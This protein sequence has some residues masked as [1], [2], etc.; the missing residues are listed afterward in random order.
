MKIFQTVDEY[1]FV[2][3]CLKVKPNKILICNKKTVFSKIEYESQIYRLYLYNL[4]LIHP[5]YTEIIKILKKLLASYRGGMIA[6]QKIELKSFENKYN[7]YFKMESNKQQSIDNLVSLIDTTNI[8]LIYLLYQQ[9]KPD[10]QDENISQLFRTAILFRDPQFDYPTTKKLYETIILAN[11]LPDLLNVINPESK[12]FIELITYIYNNT[13]PKLFEESFHIYF[14]IFYFPN[15]YDIDFDLKDDELYENLIEQYDT[16]YESDQECGIDIN[17]E[18]DDLDELARMKHL[19]NIEKNYREE[20]L[21]EHPEYDEA[22]DGYVY[23]LYSPEMVKEEIINIRKLLKKLIQTETNENRKLALIINNLEYVEMSPEES[24]PYKKQWDSKILPIIKQCGELA[25]INYK[26]H[27]IL[28]KEYIDFFNM[29][30]KELKQFYEY[31]ESTKKDIIKSFNKEKDPDVKLTLIIKYHKFLD[32]KEE[33]L[34]PYR[35]RWTEEVEPI[36]KK[37]EKEKDEIKK[38]SLIIDNF[39]FLDLFEDDKEDYIEKYNQLKNIKKYSIK[40]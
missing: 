28:K 11:N 38:L 35:K 32:M 26:Q 23:R 14:D 37:I 18:S 25:E 9:L 15:D 8:N 40:K 7:Q 2:Y 3:G 39:K 30:K 1:C 17:Y 29:S 24:D 22:K 34:T 21:K 20:F 6:V 19:L 16:K 36:L 4:N 12:K 5:F 27:I 31:Y 13:D 33:E 10:T